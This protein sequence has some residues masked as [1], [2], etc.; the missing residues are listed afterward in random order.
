MHLE[1][2]I[3]VLGRAVSSRTLFE[4]GNTRL[5]LHVWASLA[6]LL[7]ALDADFRQHRL[8]SLSELLYCIDVS[9]HGSL[10]EDYAAWP[11]NSM[12]RFQQAVRLLN[13]LI[14]E[15]QAIETG[16]GPNRLIW[17]PSC[18][19]DARQCRS[20]VTFA[21]LFIESY[22]PVAGGEI[23][24]FFLDLGIDLISGALERDSV[25]MK[26][27]LREAKIQLEPPKFLEIRER[28]RKAITR[29]IARNQLSRFREAWTG[30]IPRPLTCR[31]T[32]TWWEP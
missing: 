13:N 26:R 9:P 23:D 20:D 8:Q 3:R 18:L 21:L 1:S 14:S 4:P 17:P 28:W 5:F 7:L 19:N 6:R 2:R 29:V 15:M 11:R 25:V 16:P 30:E 31:Y 22:D 27:H 10:L 32:F 12:T 24:P